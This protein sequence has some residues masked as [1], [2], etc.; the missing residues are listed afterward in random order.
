MLNLPLSQIAIILLIVIPLISALSMQFLTLYNSVGIYIGTALM[1]VAWVSYGK[2]N[3]KFIIYILTFILYMLISLYHS[4]GGLGSLLIFTLS[5]LSLQLL[6]NIEFNSWIKKYFQ[7]FTGVMVFLLFFASFQY[8][9][10]RG[11]DY[12]GL[13][14][15][16][17]LAQLAN[18]C[19]CIY[20][21]L[22]Q[23]H[24]NKINKIL[25]LVLGLITL[26]TLIN[27]EARGA[28]VALVSFILLIN[29]PH[30]LLKPR[31][32]LFF[33]VAIVTIGTLIPFIY[34]N[35]YEQNI[36]L[37]L[38]L[39]KPLFTGRQALWI[40]AFNLFEGNIWNW[41]FGIGSK[42][43]LW[44]ASTNLHNL[45]ATVIV[46]FGI[47]GYLF[48]FCYVFKFIVKVCQNV[49][50]NDKAKR[51]F[52]MYI[53]LSL[54]QGFTETAIFGAPTIILANLGLAE[55]YRLTKK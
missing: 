45:Y 51:W 40:E 19:F 1:M 15:P 42:V 32:L 20:V 6:T 24:V 47:I 17:T 29:I 7:A 31:L 14:N 30:N 33:S 3:W 38:F 35:L 18:Y 21:C 44:D 11:F 46:D 13:V 54:I 26:S 48:Y 37:E 25:V 34:L 16:N 50:N 53:A 4:N 2:I 41:I 28:L 43:K 9:G 36:Q 10:A 5:I 49:A 23:L 12:E 8:S 55:A 27:C 52:F 22:A 39:N